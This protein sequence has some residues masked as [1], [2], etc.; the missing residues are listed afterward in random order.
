[1]VSMT[2]ARILMRMCLLRRVC[3]Q[4]TL[5][6]TIFTFNINLYFLIIHKINRYNLAF[7]Y[8][9]NPLDSLIRKWQDKEVLPIWMKHFFWSFLILLLEIPFSYFTVIYLAQYWKQS[10]YNTDNISYMKHHLFY[11]IPPWTFW[12]LRKQGYCSLMVLL[13]ISLTTEKFV[14]F[15]SKTLETS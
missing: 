10:F 7:E 14:E 6:S 1:M 11:G 13:R 9:S 5:L 15:L 8:E 3:D 12:V 4:H 2:M